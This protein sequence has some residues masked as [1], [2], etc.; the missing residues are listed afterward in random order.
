[1]KN[2]KH[3]TLAAARLQD[4]AGF[5][6]TIDSAFDKAIVAVGFEIAVQALCGQ[7]QEKILLKIA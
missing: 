6:A 7:S 2:I 5:D 1:M 3:L 4:P